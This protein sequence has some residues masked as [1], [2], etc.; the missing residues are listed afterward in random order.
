V[1]HPPLQVLEQRCT[2]VYRHPLLPASEPAA[3]IPDVRTGAGGEIDDPQRVVPR[4]GIR[5]EP[6]ERCRPRGSVGRLAQRQPCGQRVIHA[7]A[8]V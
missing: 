2:V 6:C 1:R 7:R 4:D 8:P 5:G 3:Q